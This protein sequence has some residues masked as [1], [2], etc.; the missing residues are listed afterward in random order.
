MQSCRT[1]D[2]YALRMVRWLQ[3]KDVADVLH[4]SPTSVR[5]IEETDLPFERTPRGGHRRYHPKVVLQY[6]RRHGLEPP[7]KLIQQADED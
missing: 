6:M 3:V 5:N 1:P 2:R 4:L 7:D